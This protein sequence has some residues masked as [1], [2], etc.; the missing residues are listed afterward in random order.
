[1]SVRVLVT[2]ATGSLGT[3]VVRAFRARGAEV[4]AISRGGGRVDDVVVHSVDLAESAHTL[5]ALSAA[6]IR[7]DCVVHLAAA[8]PAGP[9]APAMQASFDR[10]TAI[11]STVAA[12]CRATACSLVYLSGTAVYGRMTGPPPVTEERAVAPDT[13]YTAAKAAG[14]L[15]SLEVHAATG[16]P[17]ACL[18][19]SAPYGPGLRRPTVI[20]MFLRAALSSNELLVHG[21]GERGQDFTFA[22]DVAH[23]AVRA[24]EVGASGIFNIATGEPVTMRRLAELAREVVPGSRSRI[25]V[26]GF[27]DPEEG[28]FPVIDVAKAH[29]I[30]GWQAQTTLVDGL[31]VTLDAIEARA[32]STT[33]RA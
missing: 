33:L 8:L 5:D 25:A 31:R 10:T 17:V 11:D 12:F 30:L 29:E 26:G 14:E 13:P 2:G 18:R 27:P 21:S 20:E 1:M 23:A 3:H 7:C 16:L 15:S 4:V 32:A 6:R 22:G 24:V 28:F 19:V 9:S